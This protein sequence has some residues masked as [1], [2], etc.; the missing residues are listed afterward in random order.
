LRKYEHITAIANKRQRQIK[1]ALHKSSRFVADFCVTHNI[2]QVVIGHNKCW[3]QGINIGKLNNQKFIAIPHTIL[4]NQLRYK[5]EALG[6]TVIV[7]EESYTSQASALDN[8]YIPT[9]GDD[10]IPMFSG[11]RVKR[12]LYK[13]SNKTLINA[14]INAALNILR[15][16]SGELVACRGLV[17]RPTVFYPIDRTSVRKERTM[18]LAA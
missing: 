3:K 15:K 4:I 8:D 10:V 1:D 18:P 6:V 7:R 9:K 17:N 5:L 2:G 11:K 12:G 14:D 16:E 13:S